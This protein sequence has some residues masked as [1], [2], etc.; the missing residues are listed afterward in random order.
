[1]ARRFDAATI[2]RWAVAASVDPRSITKVLRGERVRGMAH[3]R[4]VELLE[5]EG[6]MVARESVVEV[7]A[8]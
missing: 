4:I 1:M 7:R 8:S 6:I 3:H 2:R 5:R